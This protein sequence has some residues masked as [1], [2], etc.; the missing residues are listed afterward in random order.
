M[1]HETALSWIDR[2]SDVVLDDECGSVNMGGIS[3]LPRLGS[4]NRRLQSTQAARRVLDEFW[5]GLLCLTHKPISTIAP[6]PR[7]AAR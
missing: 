6:I 1:L 2:H 3:C 4:L 5:K 7:V